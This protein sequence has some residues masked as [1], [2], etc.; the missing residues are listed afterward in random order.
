[1]P[2]TLT[3]PSSAR[4]RPA[5]KRMS[6]VL[7]AP[8]GPTNAVS[9]P[10]STFNGTAFSAVTISPLS[11]RKVF[12]TPRATRAGV[13]SLAFINQTSR[14]GDLETRRCGNDQTRRKGD[15]ETRRFRISEAQRHLDSFRDYPRLRSIDHG[16]QHSQNFVVDSSQGTTIIN[17]EVPT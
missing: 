1:M 12:F 3:S 11:R 16:D 17:L 2:K 8:S 4:I 10:C 15:L 14:Q 5:A 9:A 6:V 7:P 13:P